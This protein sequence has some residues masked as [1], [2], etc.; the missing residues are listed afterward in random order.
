MPHAVDRRA[1]ARGG[2]ARRGRRVEEIRVA[3]SKLDDDDYV[4]AD[5]AQFLL[6]I[7]DSRERALHQIWQQ[8]CESMKE[9]ARKELEQ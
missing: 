9:I 6:S 2:E 1:K 8:G 4:S 7:I 5:N 3:I